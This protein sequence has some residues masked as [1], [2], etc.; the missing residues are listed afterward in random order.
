MNDYISIINLVSLMFAAVDRQDWAEVH[1]CMT[2]TIYVDYS[3]YSG[4]EPGDMLAKDITAQW[5]A[6]MPHLDHVHHQVGNQIVEVDGNKAKV[7]AHGM[8][9]HVIEGLPAGN[10]ELVVG[11]YDFNLAK[12]ADGWKI[13]S[14]RFNF[15]FS[16]GNAE[17]STEAQRRMAR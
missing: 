8:A 7:R 5:G 12:Q 17:V 4:Q 1:D 16:S 3:S 10:L 14:M 6:F 11:T 13:S 15:K 2:E 9:S